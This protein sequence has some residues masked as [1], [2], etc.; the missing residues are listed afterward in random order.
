[1]PSPRPIRGGDAKAHVILGLCVGGML[2]ARTTDDTRLR[3][4]MR[5]ASLRHALALL[6]ER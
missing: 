6:E 1:M 2:I 3:R 5:A 4:S